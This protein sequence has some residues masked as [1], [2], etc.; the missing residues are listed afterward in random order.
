MARQG[1]TEIEIPTYNTDWDS[2]AYLTVSGQNSNNSVRVTNDFL[3]KVERGENWDLTSRITGKVM[4]STA[5][6]PLGSDR[7]RGLGLC[8]PGSAVRQ[9]HQRVA[10]LPRG[11]S[12]QRVEPLFRVHVPRRHR[13]Q[14]RLAEPDEVPPRAGHAGYRGLRTRLR[15]WTIDARDLGADGAVPVP[16]SPLSYEYRTL[17]L[18]FANIGALLM[19]HGIPY[20]SAEG[21]AIAGRHHRADDRRGLRHLGGNRRGAGAF[22]HTSERGVMLRVIRNHR[23]AAYAAEKEYEGLTITPVRWTITARTGAARRTPRV[24]GTVR[25]ILVR[26]TATATRRSRWSPRRAPSAW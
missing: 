6:R 2:D 10:H 22:P 11:R 23:R 1:F 12:D 8:R 21:R 16:K 4:K 17:G 25:W 19:V 13:L 9:H 15:L 7:L 20:D 14:P 18:G 24:A 26:S 5:R 3:G